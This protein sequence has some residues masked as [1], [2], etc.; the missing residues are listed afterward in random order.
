MKETGDS[1]APF[2][3][4]PEGMHQRPHA[5]AFYGSTKVPHPCNTAAEKVDH[6]KVMGQVLKAK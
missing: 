2:C 3:P 6:A 4:M 1:N 5:P